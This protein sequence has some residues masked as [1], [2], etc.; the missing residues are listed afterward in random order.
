MTVKKEFEP[1]QLIQVDAS[2]KPVGKMYATFRSD[3]ATF[4][5]ELDP[6]KSYEGQTQDARDRLEDRIY[7]EWELYGDS[8]KV[9]KKWLKTEAGK[10]LIN[11]RF[12]LGRLILA[13]EDKPPEIN[14]QHWDDLVK[15]RNKPSWLAKSK[16]MASIAK[17]RG[18][19]NSTHVK[20]EHTVSNR[21]VRVRKP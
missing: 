5:K 2:G 17:K 1:K 8:T 12:T 3:I 19:R 13:R 16:T 20:V 18:V 11:N 7:T 15:M 10:A 6:S 14:K 21:L 4:A 9:S